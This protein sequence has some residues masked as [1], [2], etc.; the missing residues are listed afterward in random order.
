MQFGI[1]LKTRKITNC[2]KGN[3]ETQHKV[4]KLSTNMFL[5]LL[6][7]IF[8]LAHLSS[9]QRLRPVERAALQNDVWKHV[10]KGPPRFCLKVESDLLY[11]WPGG[12]RPFHFSKYCFVII[13]RFP[14]HDHK[15]QRNLL[16]MVAVPHEGIYSQ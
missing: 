1:F 4:F 11:C 10:S 8:P 3:I 2:T 5:M 14:L 13:L 12:K 6:Y 7:Y 16:G 9:P 15:Y